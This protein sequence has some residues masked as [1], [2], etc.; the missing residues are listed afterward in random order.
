MKRR[1]KGK[2]GNGRRRNRRMTRRGAFLFYQTSPVPSVVGNELSLN[3]LVRADGGAY[4]CIA[5]NQV[6]HF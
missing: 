3:K 1:T 5:N 2:R 6:P 4:L